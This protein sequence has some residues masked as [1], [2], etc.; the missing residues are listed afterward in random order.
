MTKGDRQHKILELISEN[1]ISTQEDLNE[2]LERSGVFVNQSSVSRDLDQ[3]GIIKVNGNYTL[4]ETRSEA[5]IFG[6]SSLETAGGNLIVA[7]CSLGLASAACVKLDAAAIHE[8]VG[9]I[10]GEDTIF[11]AVKDAKTQ[12]SAMRKI[13]ELFEK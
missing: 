1:E 5:N 8:I 4:P 2:L 10:A 13:W 7:K 9:T 6:L 11:I 3:L 12:K